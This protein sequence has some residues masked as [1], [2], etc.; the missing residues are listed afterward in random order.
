MNKNLKFK[1]K[2]CI[3]EEKIKV[4]LLIR[5][6]KLCLICLINFNL[7]LNKSLNVNIIFM[8]YLNLSKITIVL[9]LKNQKDIKKAQPLKL[10]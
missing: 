1:M 3:L 7:N 10:G 9:Y 2:K 4:F 6:Y 8:I 5:N